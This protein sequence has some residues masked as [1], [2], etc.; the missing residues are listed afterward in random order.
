[1][2]FV[3]FWT[4]L[5]RYTWLFFA[6]FFPTIST[7]GCFWSQWPTSLAVTSGCPTMRCGRLPS[8]S[9][10]N[11]HILSYPLGAYHLPH[12]CWICVDV[13]YLFS[14]LT[15]PRP[16]SS[17]P[18]CSQKQCLANA[19]SDTP[20]LSGI[21][22]QSVWKWG[23]PPKKNGNVNRGTWWKTSEFGAIQLASFDLFK[24]GCHYKNWLSPSFCRDPVTPR[25]SQN[26]WAHQPLPE[27]APRTPVTCKFCRNEKI[28]GC[29]VYKEC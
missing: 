5:V 16:W 14:G 3:I 28:K 24:A 7:F 1:M 29:P 20:T 15:L 8:R 13:I 18:C 10:V 21:T 17:F 6:F 4:A 26:P 23:I 12:D 25:G 27:A 11:I 22:S 2:F 9:D 19:E